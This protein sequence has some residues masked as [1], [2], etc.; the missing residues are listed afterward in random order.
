M[1]GAG[2]LA[3][4]TAAIA[5]TS[6]AVPVTGGLSYI[7]AAPIAVWSGVDVAVIILASAIG[8]TLLI[9]IF[10]NYEEISYSAGILVL[11]KRQGNSGDK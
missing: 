7:V 10:R 6:V 9:A 8:L 3:P 2:T 5:A 4:L 11:R 1:V